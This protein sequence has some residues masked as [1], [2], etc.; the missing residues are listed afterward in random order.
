MVLFWVVF[1]MIY[2]HDYRN[3]LSLGGSRDDDFPGTARNMSASLV[4]VGEYTCR[5]D[6]D[7]RSE[8]APGYIS[9]VTL[10]ECLDLLTVNCEGIFR[11]RY[12]PVERT[13]VTVVH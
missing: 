7:L 5:L 3:I 6:D 2:T 10:C 4:C 9:G 13:V 1:F 11:G 8:V 12:I